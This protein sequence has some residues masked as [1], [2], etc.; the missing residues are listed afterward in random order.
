M[1]IGPTSSIA[2]SVAG[3]PLAQTHAAHTARAGHDAA[4]QQLQAQNKL[5]TEKAEG[6]GATDGEDNETSDRD[7]DGRRL[8]EAAAKTRRK[9]SQ[10]DAPPPPLSKD[11]TGEAGQTLDLS[12]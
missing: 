12:G 9:A 3:A 7:A 2:A 4:A 10:E 11:T 5:L 6:V 1:S 8:W